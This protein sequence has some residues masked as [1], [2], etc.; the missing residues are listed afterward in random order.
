MCMHSVKLTFLCSSSGQTEEGGISVH[1]NF[2]VRPAKNHMDL[3]EE[4]AIGHF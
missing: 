3:G 2:N 4:H 1:S